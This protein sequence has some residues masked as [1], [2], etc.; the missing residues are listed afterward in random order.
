ML[1][2]N[3]SAALL[4]VDADICC[5]LMYRFDHTNADNPN[6]EPGVS[7]CAMRDAEDGRFRPIIPMPGDPL[8]QDVD[9]MGTGSMLIR[10]RVIVAGRMWLDDKYRDLNGFQMRLEEQRKHPHWAPPIFRTRLKPNGQVLMGEDV[11]FC[12]RAK[13]LGYTCKT[14]LGVSFGHL[15]EVDLN[16]VVTSIHH[17]IKRDKE[18]EAAQQVAA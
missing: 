2:T 8:V 11:D 14:H 7:I 13:R 12:Q 15:K 5:G 6:S 9:A 1:P 16:E 3:S 10:R 18:Y 17:A 4:G